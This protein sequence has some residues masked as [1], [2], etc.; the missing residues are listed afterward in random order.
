[1][2]TEQI[3]SRY[4]NIVGQ[5]GLE[6]YHEYIRRDRANSLRAE[7]VMSTNEFSN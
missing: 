4:Q 2:V 3:I 1:M 7:K 6:V 5:H